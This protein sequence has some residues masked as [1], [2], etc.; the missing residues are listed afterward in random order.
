MDLCKKCLWYYTNASKGDFCTKQRQ[1]KSSTC[2][3]YYF[4]PEEKREVCDKQKE[5]VKCQ[6]GLDSAGCGGV[7]ASYCPKYMYLS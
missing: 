1:Q 5:E 4:L 2:G 7:H 3:R 6:C